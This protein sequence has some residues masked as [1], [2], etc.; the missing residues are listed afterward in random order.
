MPRPSQ[1]LLSFWHLST[2]EV[3]QELGTKS[4]GLDTNEAAERL[5]R[6]GPNTLKAAGKK[7]GALLFLSQFKSPVTLLLII[8]SVLSAGLGDVTDT[9]IIFIIVLISGTLGFLQER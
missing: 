9:I 1:P 6:N 2:D 7:P 8:A 3:L 4:T 5:R